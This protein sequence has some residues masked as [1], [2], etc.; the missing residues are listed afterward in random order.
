MGAV[1][2]EIVSEGQGNVGKRRMI[3]RT[4]SRNTLFRVKHLEEEYFITSLPVEVMPLIPSA[5]NWV[6]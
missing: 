2:Q 3:I 4:P 5:M 6:Q 1:L